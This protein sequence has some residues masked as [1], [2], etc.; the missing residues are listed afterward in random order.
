MLSTEH[1]FHQTQSS[2]KAPYQS[3]YWI[4]DMQQECSVLTPAFICAGFV[5]QAW[6]NLTLC[7]LLEI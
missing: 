2:V 7:L 5:V 3:S 4:T 1:N 6:I